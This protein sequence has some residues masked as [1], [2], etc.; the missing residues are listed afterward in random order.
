[1]AFFT[2]ALPL[3]VELRFV[4]KNKSGKQTSRPASQ[5]VDWN[6]GDGF[7]HST[8]NPTIHIFYFVFFDAI[9]GP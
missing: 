1:M 8:A 9:F 4:E 3:L 7:V 2:E 5:P 6:G